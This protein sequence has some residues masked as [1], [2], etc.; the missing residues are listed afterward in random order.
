MFSLYGE[1][2]GLQLAHEWVR[3]GNCFFA[4]WLSVGASLEY[5]FSQDDVKSYTEE[6]EW[7]DYAA[8]VDIELP[9]FQRI[10]EVRSW[11]PHGTDP[12]PPVA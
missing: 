11:S 12:V 7:L 9:A 3:R 1:H 5:T 4:L 8:E 2:S 10:M 6:L